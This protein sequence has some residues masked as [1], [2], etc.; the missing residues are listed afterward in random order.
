MWD[1]SSPARDGTCASCS[2]KQRILTTPA[3]DTLKSD[4]LKRSLVNCRNTQTT[5][6][7]WEKRAWT[8]EGWQRNRSHKKLK[9]NSWKAESFKSRLNHTSL[10]IQWLRIHL[11]GRGHGSD[12]WEDSTCRGATKPTITEPVLYSPRATTIEPMCCSRCSP[13]HP[14]PAHYTK[15]S[16]RNEKPVYCNLSFLRQLEKACLQ[17]QRPRTARNKYFFKKIKKKKKKYT[18]LRVGEN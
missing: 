6:E 11:P 2:G 15:G 14:K 17:Q 3:R 18:Q 1:L 7:N 12:P 13:L 9:S 16:Q 5:K 8:K 4:T 10:V